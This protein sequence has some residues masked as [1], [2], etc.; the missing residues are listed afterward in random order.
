MSAEKSPVLVK[1]K[2]K[3]RDSSG[4][5][6]G[7]GRGRAPLGLVRPLARPDDTDDGETPV[8]IGT[9]SRTDLEMAKLDRLDNAALAALAQPKPNSTSKY[10]FYVK[11]GKYQITEI[12][13][14]TI[15]TKN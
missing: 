7:K 2:R 15:R 10:N 13:K 1:R 12:E 14:F 6:R 8:M 3:S 5:G 11:L 9:R 4:R